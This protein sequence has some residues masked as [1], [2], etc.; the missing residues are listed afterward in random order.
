MRNTML[1]VVIV[2]ILLA[3]AAFAQEVAPEPGTDVNQATD[4]FERYGLAGLAIVATVAIIGIAWYVVKKRE[5]RDPSPPTTPLGFTAFFAVLLATLPLSGCASGIQKEAAARSID[6]V[7]KVVHDLEG[8]VVP[9]I[10]QS[11]RDAN[12]DQI[13]TLKDSVR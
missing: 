1:A 11:E 8:R 7:E 9:P 10:A 5:P 6:V 12:Q 13:N 4:L 2:Y 3:G